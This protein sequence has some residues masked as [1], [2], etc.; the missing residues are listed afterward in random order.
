MKKALV[1]G[2]GGFLGFAIVK[3]LIEKKYSVRSISRSHYKKLDEIGVEQIIGDIS[4]PYDAEKAVQGMDIVFHVAAK[5]GIWGKYEE[6]YNINYIGTKNIA[7]FS[8]KH[9]VKEFIYTSSPS[10]I[11]DGNDMENVD[12]SVPYPVEFHTHYPKTKA[13]AEKY[14]QEITKKGLKT[15]TLRPHLIWGPDDNHLVPRIIKKAKRLKKIGYEKKLVDT[16]YID[17]AADAHILAAEKLSE[18]IDLSGKIY[19]ISQDEPIYTW[20]MIDRILESAGKPKIKGTVS[21]SAAYYVGAFLEFIFKIFFIKSEPPMTRFVAKEL[22]T[23]HYFD[24]SAVKT[25]LGFKP[26]ISITK[27][28]KI[29]KDH[30]KGTSID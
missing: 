21:V 27:G 17:N 1:T 4:I 10:V 8:L 15:I 26:N 7:D 3:Q 9:N 22:S 24:I 5:P 14:I 18:N 28:L 23:S 11:F 30:L 19:F 29:L 13:L 6:Y 20:D 25:D 16:I 2:G 12:E